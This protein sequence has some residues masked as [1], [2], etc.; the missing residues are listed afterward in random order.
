MVILKNP[1][2]AMIAGSWVS[3][4]NG[5]SGSEDRQR[6]EGKATNLLSPKPQPELRCPKVSEVPRRKVGIAPDP[7]GH[8]SAGA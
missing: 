3:T 8:V 2:I 5:P 6:R 1:A 4:L 7:A